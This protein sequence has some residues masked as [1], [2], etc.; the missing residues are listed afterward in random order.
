MSESVI[1]LVHCMQRSSEKFLH[2]SKVITCDSF[3]SAGK[4]DICT[5]PETITSVEGLVASTSNASASCIK[6]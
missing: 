1:Q 5:F 2:C 4:C 3:H 6:R